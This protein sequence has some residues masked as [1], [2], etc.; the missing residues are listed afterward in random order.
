MSVLYLHG[1][2]SEYKPDSE[3]IRALERLGIVS[4]INLY[5]GKGSEICIERAKLAF[6]SQDIDLAVGTSM[7]GW[8]ASHVGMK[9]G[10]PFVALNT[11]VSPSESLKKHVVIAVNYTGTEHTVEALG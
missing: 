11:A 9:C 10:I 8:L 2:G 4:G 1:Y 6:I 3:K 7:G 5:Y